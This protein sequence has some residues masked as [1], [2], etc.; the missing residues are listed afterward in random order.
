MIHFHFEQSSNLND[1]LAKKFNFEIPHSFVSQNF[2][3]IIKTS[4]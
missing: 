2:D 3:N 4:F 1:Q